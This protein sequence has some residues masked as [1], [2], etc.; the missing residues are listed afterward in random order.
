MFGL[1]DKRSKEEKFWTWFGK[2]SNR[3]LTL[4]K[5][6]RAK[7][8]DELNREIHKV[9]SNL[10]FE[11]SPLFDNGLRK[12]IISAD[13][14]KESFPSVKNLVNKAPVIPNWD[15]IAFRQPKA[16]YKQIRYK[17][18]TIDFK[19]VYFRYSK[20]NG[21]IGL[22]LNIKEYE[23]T[24]EWNASTFLLLDMVVGEFDTEMFLSWIERKK[25]D[26]K[27]IESLYQIEELPTIL[28]DYK[29]EFSN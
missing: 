8:F 24:K 13:G 7:L 9:D 14:I 26:E 15:I 6:N 4:D 5:S 20:D 22:E 19:D 25:L 11:F 12:F 16:D 28:N 27:Q 10:T 21:K 23:E 17:G 1:F 3:Y 2:N 29:K 18:I